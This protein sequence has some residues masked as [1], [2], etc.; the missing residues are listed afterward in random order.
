MKK[1]A[2]LCNI[3]NWA[4]QEDV[5]S[6]IFVFQDSK[7]NTMTTDDTEDSDIQSGAFLY[8]MKDSL[9]LLDAH[10]IFEPLLSSLSVMPQQMLSV[11]GSGNVNNMSSLDSLGSNLSLVGSMDTMRIDIVVSEFGKVI[12][13]KKSKFELPITSCIQT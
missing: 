1:S 12:D 3:V 8:P 10:L 13:K 11:I 6:K 5:Q 7:I 4:I 9:R 2:S